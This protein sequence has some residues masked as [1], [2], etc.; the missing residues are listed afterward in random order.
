MTDKIIEHREASMELKNRLCIQLEDLP[1]ILHL[2]RA[3]DQS[4]VFE[5]SHTL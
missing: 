4:R 5:Y 1:G 2:L 3:N